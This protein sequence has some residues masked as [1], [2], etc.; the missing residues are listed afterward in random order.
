M[1]PPAAADADP[2]ETESE[3]LFG[4]DTEMNPELETLRQ[5]LQ[6]A[7]RDRDMQGDF[8]LRANEAL[9]KEPMVMKQGKA[10]AR[11]VEKTVRDFKHYRE[12]GQTAELASATLALAMH[13]PQHL[14]QVREV[15]R[16]AYLK[17][18]QQKRRSRNAEELAAVRKRNVRRV[19]EAK[20][21]V[22][23]RHLLK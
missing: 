4:S 16:Q 21:A 14:L 18:L 9:L 8:I 22:R 15:E 7:N 1:T 13:W 19:S 12:L 6:E 11:S 20:N 3:H 10:V 2:A 5:E 23:A 17:V